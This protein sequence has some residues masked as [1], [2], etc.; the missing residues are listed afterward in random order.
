[1]N[2]R[3]YFLYEDTFIFICLFSKVCLISSTEDNFY[4]SFPSITSQI[5][6]NQETFEI[7]VEIIIFYIYVDK[8]DIIIE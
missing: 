6:S 1:M 3:L 5:L 8:I 4:G 2:T 7:K